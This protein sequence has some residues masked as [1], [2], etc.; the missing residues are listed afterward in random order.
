MARPVFPPAARLRHQASR[1]RPRASLRAR[2]LSTA[3]YLSP[4]SPTQKSPGNLGLGS[5]SSL[6]RISPSYRVAS[7]G[8]AINLAGPPA[9][10]VGQQRARTWMVPSGSFSASHVNP[11]AG[12]TRGGSGVAPGRFLAYRELQGRHTRHRPHP[13]PRLG[14]LHRGAGPLAGVLATTAPLPLPAQETCVSVPTSY[15][16]YS[17]SIRVLK[18]TVPP[19]FRVGAASPPSRSPEA[20]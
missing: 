8:E 20:P 19:P 5:H 3:G 7:D 1:E 12:F 9:L 2:S 6:S 15:A 13:S 18:L 11:P 10:P 17:L 14:Q 16:S 4:K